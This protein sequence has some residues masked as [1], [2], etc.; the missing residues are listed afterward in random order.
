MRSVRLCYRHV[1]QAERWKTIDAT[2]DQG[3]YTAAIPGEYTESKF[4]LEY[5][6]EL[7]DGKGVQWMYP[8]FNKSFSN[9]PYF[10]VC[11]RTE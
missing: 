5:Y 7:E 3:A 4:A 10:A 2:R 8:G 9:Q 6:F 11:K 1:N